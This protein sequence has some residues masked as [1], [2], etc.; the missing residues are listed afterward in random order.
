MV[1][2][3][4]W[5]LLCVAPTAPAPAPAAPTATSELA[6]PFAPPRAKPRIPPGHFRSAN[7]ELLSP[8]S[9]RYRNVR[10]PVR[11]TIRSPFDA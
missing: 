5:N 6:D 10:G 1:A 2:L 4:V 3:L 7:P 9:P 11:P 8:F